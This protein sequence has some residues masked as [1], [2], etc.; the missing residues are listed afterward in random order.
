MTAQRCATFDPSPAD[1]AAALESRAF[2]AYYK[3]TIACASRALV[4]FEAL[5][6]W[7]RPDLS[8]VRPDQFTRLA[9]QSGQMDELTRQVIQNALDWFAR[10]LTGTGLTITLNVSATLLADPQA[11]AWLFAC[12][13]RLAIDPA[14]VV[15]AVT[16]ADAVAHL[17]K[18][19]RVAMQL[20]IYGFRFC[21]SAFGAG[22]SSLRLLAQLP[23]SEL[24]MDRRF[25]IQAAESE[26]S[27]EMIGSII[28]MSRA[29]DLRV[30]AA[31]VRDDQ[32]LEFLNRKGCHAAQGSLIAAPMEGAAAM[33]WRRS[34]GPGL[35]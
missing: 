5:P 1:L 16:E 15:L 6:R 11:P 35:G 8:V 14:R 30:T 12:C 31:G 29:V 7:R 32:T 24:K 18:I 9:E 4:G 25:V 26:S 10:S 33:A 22:R 17:A 19:S 27:R 2:E 20:R 34:Y 3:P 13:S 28:A 23:F 21:V